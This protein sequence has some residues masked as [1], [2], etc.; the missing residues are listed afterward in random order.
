MFNPSTTPFQPGQID[1]TMAMLAS[2]K[3]QG[4]LQQ[5][6]MQH[7]CNPNLV[8]LASQVN[9]MSQQSA[10][11]GPQ[12]TVKDQAIQ[13]MGQPSQ[14]GAPTGQPEQTPDPEMEI[15]QAIDESIAN[16][17]FETAKKLITKLKD[18]DKIEPPEPMVP[19]GGALP[20]DNPNMPHGGSP[21]A[22]PEEQGIG[23]LPA[24][25]LQGMGHADGG[26]I[27]YA[28]GG[29]GS[30]Y[31]PLTDEDISAVLN[32]K[33]TQGNSSLITPEQLQTKQE[34][35]VKP[36]NQ[37]VESDYA[38]FAQ[39]IAQKQAKLDA[40][41]GNNLGTA[42]L[43]AGL[44]MMAGTSPYAM[45]NIGQ[46]G[47]KGL[48][49]YTAAQ[50]A[51]QQAQDAL[52]NSN[53]SLMQAKRAEKSGN[54]RDA[55]LL[56]DTAQKQNDAKVAHGLASLQL[57]NTSQYQNEEAIAKRIQLGNEAE[58]IKSDADWHKIY[59]DYLTNKSG[60]Q[61]AEQKEVDALFAKQTAKAIADRDALIKQGFPSNVSKINALSAEINQVADNLY[62]SRPHLQHPG[63][64]T[65]YDPKAAQPQ[66]GPH[67]WSEDIPGTLQAM[68]IQKTPPVVPK[69]GIPNT[70]GLP[71]AQQAGAPAIDFSALPR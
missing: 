40:S 7:Q 61:S 25:N 34:A 3:D 64:Q 22:L 11:P 20:G 23:T 50:K 24:Q 47:L 33:D 45:A 46:G 70:N 29:T 38:P 42:L 14:P 4:K 63:Y 56:M 60:P 55:A 49:T 69:Q 31:K 15:R 48:E 62:G 8:A 71:T 44:G 26:I 54:Y 5:Y 68:P 18:I 30:T 57:K 35:M 53:L 65:T 17:D 66:A 51:D 41:S 9:S 37:Q 28:G 6:V 58:K 36:K 13:A 21:M 12:T 19:G 2:L 39:R 1:Q 27:G 59:G 16:K 67:F 52:D 10:Q 43:T 32:P